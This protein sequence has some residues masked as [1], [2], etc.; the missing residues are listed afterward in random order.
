MA[1]YNKLNAY[2]RACEAATNGRPISLDYEPVEG[3]VRCHGDLAAVAAVERAARGRKLPG[4]TL[5]PSTGAVRGLDGVYGVT[6]IER[7]AR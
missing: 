1:N 7:D 4:L 2:A 6:L 5:A 3:L